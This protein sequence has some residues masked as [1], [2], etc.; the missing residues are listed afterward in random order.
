M[1]TLTITNQ[2]PYTKFGPAVRF[3]CQATI[4]A[5]AIGASSQA[6]VTGTITGLTTDMVLVV[7]APVSATN[8]GLINAQV[9]AADT[10]SLS[11][12]NPAGSATPTSGTYVILGL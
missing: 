10:I 9:T 2:V 7:S 1:A 3:A 8:A 5:G 4:D 11:Y 6:S 12:V